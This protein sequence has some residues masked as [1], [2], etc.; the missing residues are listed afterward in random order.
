M[1]VITKLR[2]RG[3]R[4]LKLS[5]LR[6]IMFNK[7]IIRSV[8]FVLSHKKIIKIIRLRSKH[9][10]RVT[11]EKIQIRGYLRFDIALCSVQADKI[12]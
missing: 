5:S 8:T 1:I 12:K 7:L 10:G 6:K 11:M 2:L 3:D 9:A 4:R